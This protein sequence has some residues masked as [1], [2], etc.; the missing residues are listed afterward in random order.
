MSKKWIIVIIVVACAFGGF[1]FYQN[2]TETE[3]RASYISS[4]GNIVNGGFVFQADDWIYYSGWGE[5]GHLFKVRTDGTGKQQLGDDKNCGEI[6]VV[7]D[8]VYYTNDV[9]AISRIQTNGKRQELL[10]SGDGNSVTLNFLDNWIYYCDYW[11]KDVNKIR[12]NGKN[13]QLIYNIY[14]CQQIILLDDWIYYYNLYGGIY[15]LNINDNRQE[16]ISA[17]T[18][19]SFTI[20]ENWIYYGNSDENGSL[21]KIKIDGTGRESLNQVYSFSLNAY[22][23]WVYYCNKDDNWYIYRIRTD[24]TGDE[25]LNTD[26]SNTINIAGDWV[27]YVIQKHEKPYDMYKLSE[28]WRMRFDGSGREKV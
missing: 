3:P 2:Q 22:D 28:L 25:R 26:K 19:K 20:C 15:K 5:D 16:E 18:A 8:W 6:N 10:F 12:T 27:Y 13:N 17:D 24:G 23:D 9:G 7:G 4:P 1:L 14:N 11:N 21:Y